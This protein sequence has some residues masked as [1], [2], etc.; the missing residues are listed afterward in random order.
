[1]VINDKS[2]GSVVPCLRCGEFFD[3]C[4]ITN[5]LLSFRSKNFQNQ[6]TFGKIRDKNIMAPF[7]RHSTLCICSEI[8]SSETA[9]TN[10]AAVAEMTFK[11]H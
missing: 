2:Q 9:D 4:F 6:S 8:L 10:T 1:M 7:F 11:G 3:Y 5:L